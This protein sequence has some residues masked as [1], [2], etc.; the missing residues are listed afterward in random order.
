MVNVY[1]QGL[2]VK[3]TLEDVAG[4]RPTSEGPEEQSRVV[5]E[6]V[7]TPP[8]GCGIRPAQEGQPAPGPADFPGA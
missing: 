3:V 6:E 4:P 1:S 8:V 2:E 5:S 7:E